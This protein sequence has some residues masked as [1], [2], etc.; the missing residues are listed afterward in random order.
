MSI[1]DRLY[2][3]AK[4]HLDL[5]VE[6][7]GEIDQRAQQELDNFMA[8]HTDNNNVSAWDRAVNKISAG[9]AE[10]ELR[11]PADQMEDSP[12]RPEPSLDALE[13]SLAAQRT[14][15]PAPAPGTASA[16]PQTPTLLAAY[17]VLGVEPGSDYLTVQKAYND[18]R[19][20]A[21]PDRFPAGSKEQEAARN[22]QKRIESAHMMLSNILSP[23]S[24]RFDRLEL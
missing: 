16:N 9:A 11:S 19:E 24:D 8:S 10:K 22:I 6:R 4:A 15:A 3:I 12:M 13:A 5:A 2:N 1:P 23:K 14:S 21:S 17:K 20:R 18:L 7:W